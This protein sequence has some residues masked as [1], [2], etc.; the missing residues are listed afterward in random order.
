MFKIFIIHHLYQ[1][2]IESVLNGLIFNFVLTPLVKDMITEGSYF[3]SVCIPK[4]SHSTMLYNCS[5]SQINDIGCFLY[6]THITMVVD[7][8]DVN[9]FELY[10]KLCNRN[11]VN[12]YEFKLIKSDAKEATFMLNVYEIFVKWSEYSSVIFNK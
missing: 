11:L 6:A 7:I 4:Q 1:Y 3:S 10:N 12:K 9:G 2:A 5:V 8:T